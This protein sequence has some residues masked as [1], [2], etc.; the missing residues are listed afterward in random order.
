MISA[1]LTDAM[2][3]LFPGFTGLAAKMSDYS[4]IPEEQLQARVHE[5][6][7]D[8]WELCR[9]RITEIEFWRRFANGIIWKLDAKANII[10]PDPNVFLQAFRDNMKRSVPGTFEIYRSLIESRQ[11]RSL[12][13]ASDHVREIVP[14]LVKWH[15][16]VFE[17][18]SWDRRFWSCEIGM[19]K[20]DPGFFPLVLSVMRSYGHTRN[21]ILSIDG[22]EE[23]V[24]VAREDN[25]MNAIRFTSAEQLA[26]D[27]RAYGLKV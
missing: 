20:R 2:D 7:D 10:T 1:I 9:G 12:F 16:E 27:L 4:G 19:V 18:I 3:V 6:L 21:E 24:R 25:E 13:L 5:M 22:S 11:V 15:P 14:L 26:K 8:L 17:W 23:N